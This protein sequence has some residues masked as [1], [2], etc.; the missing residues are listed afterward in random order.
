MNVIY[1]IEILLQYIMNFRIS[2][3]YLT[4]LKEN[5]E[6]PVQPQKGTKKRQI[7]VPYFV[8]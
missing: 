8:Q 4:S 3:P 5:S 1:Y 6:T 2:I 7:Q